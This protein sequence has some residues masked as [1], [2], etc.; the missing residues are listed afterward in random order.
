MGWQSC[1]PKSITLKEIMSSVYVKQKLTH[2]QTYT[3]IP[4]HIITVGWDLPYLLDYQLETDSSILLTKAGTALEKYK[5]HA[6]VANELSTRKEQVVVVTGA[7]K[8]K[9]QRD[10]S[11]SVNDV[12]D[13]LINL[14]SERHGPY[15]EASAR[16]VYRMTL[17]LNLGFFSLLRFLGTCTTTL[18]AWTPRFF[19]KYCLSTYI[20]RKSSAIWEKCIWEKKYKPH[21]FQFSNKKI[22][23]LNENIGFFH[24]LA[25]WAVSCTNGATNIMLQMISDNEI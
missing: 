8:I 4:W 12:E 16:W 23:V 20:S 11:M 18:V 17:A 6:V 1:F 2:T 19:I 24:S 22:L 3:Q 7:E 10:K 21:M 25:N 15:I 5:M 14:L 13:P 9:V